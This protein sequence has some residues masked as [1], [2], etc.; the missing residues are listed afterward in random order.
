V[1]ATHLELSR[2]IKTRKGLTVLVSV[3]E[4]GDK[5]IER[6]QWLAAS[7]ESI[8]TAYGQSEPDYPVAMVKE[9]NPDYRT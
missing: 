1:D 3:A 4:S 7:A 5:E 2:P 6:Q 9:C 8:E